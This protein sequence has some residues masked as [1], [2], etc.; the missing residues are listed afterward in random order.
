[1]AICYKTTVPGEISATLVMTG[2]YRFTRNPMYVGLTLAYLG[3][4]GIL[5]QIWPIIVLPLLFAYLNWMVTPL[6]EAR[7]KEAFGNKKGVLGS[8]GIFFDRSRHTGTVCLRQ[9]KS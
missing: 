8:N 1:M 4:A 6:E 5:I 2:P 3:E 9:R 7:L